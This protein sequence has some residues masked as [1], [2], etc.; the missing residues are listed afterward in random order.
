MANREK[1]EVSLV[2][3]GTSYTLVLN[4][5][6]MIAAEEAASTPSKEVTWD[7]IV[8]KY[9]SGSA[10]YVRIFLWAMLH[11]FHPDMTL[12][13]VGELVDEAGGVVEFARALEAGQRALTPDPED[14]KALGVEAKRPRKARNDGTGVISISQRA[15]SA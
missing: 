13:Q 5:A 3:G 4:M 2:V 11:K 8:T 1:G 9:S 10:K 15:A 7:Q 6:A 14:V 12:E